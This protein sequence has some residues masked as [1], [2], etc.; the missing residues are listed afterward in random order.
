MISHMCVCVCVCICVRGR[1][2]AQQYMYVCMN[3]IF[4]ILYA[5]KLEALFVIQLPVCSSVGL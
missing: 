2:R 3:T 4:Y 5:L 1:E